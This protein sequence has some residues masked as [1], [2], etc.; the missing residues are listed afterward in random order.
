M[1]K[2]RV[3]LIGRYGHPADSGGVANAQRSII[4]YAGE[5]GI[6]FHVMSIRTGSLIPEDTPKIVTY[7]SNQFRLDVIPSVKGFES[8]RTLYFES[9]TASL[10]DEVVSSLGT[11][12][13]NLVHVFCAY[14]NYVSVAAEVARRLDTLFI[15]SARGTDVYGH[16]PEYAYDPDKSWYLKP[17]TGAASITFLSYFFLIYL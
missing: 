1:T 17:L 15:V 7:G 12:P 13:V 4:R 5:M 11:E 9:A 14:P 6:D 3:L 16:N 10:A 2:P 8:K